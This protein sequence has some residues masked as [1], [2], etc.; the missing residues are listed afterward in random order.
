VHLRERLSSFRIHPGQRQ[1][2]PAKARR[3]AESIRGLQAVWLELGLHERLAPDML[4]TRP[5]APSDA[6]GWQLQPSL[7]FAARRV[8]A[9]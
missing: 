6:A 2:D 7:G 3:N 9:V 4:L 8:V 5:F 1:H